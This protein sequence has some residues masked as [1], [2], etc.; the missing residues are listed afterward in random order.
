MKLAGKVAIVTGG[1]Q[2]IGEAIARRYAAEGADIAIVSIG[3]QTNAGRI[4]AD[5]EAMGRRAHAY[6][7]DGSIVAEIENVVGLIAADFG[8]I[9]ILVNNAG[10]FRG[11]SIESTTEADWD[12][13][14]DL[15]LK[16][17]FFFARSVL[18]HLRLRGRGKIINISSVAGVGAFPNCPAYC[19]AKGGVVN[20]TRALAVELAPQKINVNSIAPGNVATQMNA[21]LRSPGSEAFL[22]TLQDRTP[23][24]RSYMQP[25]DITG[26][27]VFLAASDSDWVHGAILMVDD[28]WSL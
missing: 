23:T 24:G 4:V 17:T 6:V 12:F 27:A 16:G 20:L 15:N 11:A 7:A 26:A 5:V 21:H 8:A 14:V 2:G 28:G 13:Q 22:K 19:A 1:S 9:D 10:V 18:P 25:E 3:D